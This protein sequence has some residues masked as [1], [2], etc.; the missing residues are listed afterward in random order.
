MFGMLFVYISALKSSGSLM[1]ARLVSRYDMATLCTAP[2]MTF[3]M[4]ILSTLACDVLIGFIVEEA[5][6]TNID[7]TPQRYYRCS[8]IPIFGMADTLSIF[9]FH[10]LSY[11]YSAYGSQ[12]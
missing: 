11:M 4:L 7:P 9:T 2:N 10:S 3:L 6:L 5:H 8:G 1:T 12:P